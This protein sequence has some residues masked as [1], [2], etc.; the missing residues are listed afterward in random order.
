MEEF[1][2][3]YDICSDA[4]YLASYNIANVYGDNETD[5]LAETLKILTTDNSRFEEAIFQNFD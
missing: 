3:I 2:T 5:L 1:K 4:L